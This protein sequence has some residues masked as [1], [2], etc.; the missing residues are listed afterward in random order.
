MVRPSNQRTL[1]AGSGTAASRL[2]EFVDR[3]P[4]ARS[5]YSLSEIAGEVG[6]SRQHAFQLL[7][8]WTAERQRLQAD[9][10]RAFAQAHPKARLSN[11]S[12][13]LDW[14]QIAEEIGLP[15]TTVRR[16]WRALRLPNENEDR[17]D[18][19]A[20]KRRRADSQRRRHAEVLRLET[21]VM[22]SVRFPWTTQHEL[23]RKY[24]G[25]SVTCSQSCRQ[26]FHLAR[27]DKGD[28]H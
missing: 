27:S 3:H 13:R 28:Q 12:N 6:I 23:T 10:V 22:C 4:D 25:R 19:E 24:H 7:P 5:R 15:V 17:R 16:I 8:R 1:S 9:Q 11:P 18:P 14:R 26:R 2:R 21:C 20:I